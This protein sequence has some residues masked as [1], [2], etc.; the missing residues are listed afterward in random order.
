MKEKLIKDI[1]REIAENLFNNGK[2]EP[3]NEFTPYSEL[4]DIVRG[5]IDYKE[6]DEDVSDEDIYTIRKCFT[7]YF[8]EL[9]KTKTNYKTEL[10]NCNNNTYL[11]VWK[12]TEI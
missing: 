10:Y 8:T 2:F 7:R 12:D 6:L 11:R 9:L 3:K 1:G 4:T 5:W